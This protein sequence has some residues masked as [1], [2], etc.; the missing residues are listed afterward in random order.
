MAIGDALGKSYA[1]SKTGKTTI[2]INVSKSDGSQLTSKEK[3]ELINSLKEI[4]NLTK[5]DNLITSIQKI[6]QGLADKGAVLAV[7]GGGLAVAYT[8]K[9][10]GDFDKEHAQS[11]A[12]TENTAAELNLNSGYVVGAFGGGMAVSNREGSALSKTTETITTNVNGSEVVGL[13]ANGGAVHRGADKA[14]QAV[15]EAK[16]T[17]VNVVAGSVDG[18]FGGGLAV[19]SEDSNW[20]QDSS[21]VLTTGQST[22]NIASNVNKLTYDNLSTFFTSLDGG[23]FNNHFKEVKDLAQNAAIVGGGVAAGHGALSHVEKVVINISD[24]A[25]IQ[26]DIIAGGI[27]AHGSHS[28]VN[29]AEVNWDGGK[30]AGAIIGQGL[31]DGAKVANSTLNITGNVKIEPLSDNRSKINGFNKIVFSQGT[32][33]SIEGLTAGNSVALIDGKIDGQSNGTITTQGSRLD[34][35]KLAANEN[36]YFIATNYDKDKSSLWSNANLAFDRTSYFANAEEDSNGNYNITYKELSAAS[37]EEKQD[38]LNDFVNGLGRFGIQSRGIIEGIINNGTNT[39]DGAKSFFADASSSTSDVSNDLARGLLFGE[40]SGVTSNTISMAND[41]AENAFLRLSL[42]QGPSSKT[43]NALW[44]KYLHNKY[45]VNGL[46]S[47]FDKLHSNNTYD[48]FTVGL[49]LLTHLDYA[50]AGFAISYVDGD[51]DGSGVDNEY[52]MWGATIYGNITNQV[53]NLIAD[54]NY[55]VGDNDLSGYSNAK[56]LSASRDL[57]VLSVGTRLERMFTVNSTQIIPYAGLRYMNVDA[58]KYTTK[59][60]GK[61]AFENKAD[62]QNIWTVPVG[63]NLRNT[64]MT[65]NGWTLSPNLNVAYVSAFGD[66]DNNVTV[67]AGSGS[68][69]LNYDVIDSGS[70][71]GQV[72]LEAEY[73]DLKFGA[74]YSYQ[75][76]SDTQSNKFFVNFDYRF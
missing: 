21:K 6:T 17:I 24:G 59:Y 16:D 44:V 22:L 2:N 3:G 73:K 10:F 69:V 46:A 33:A 40:M 32:E 31:G 4:S 72:S 7:T 20:D 23:A 37:A 54:I 29:N 47:S 71:L 51:G 12:V 60:D 53:Y 34:I 5:S 15:V 70:C 11:E 9:T 66:T 67:H 45:E 28:T 41:I 50:K 57:S 39:N 1:E 75:K 74:G 61:V 35:S 55:S 36:K 76:G 48:G 38:A 52:D 30:F 8:D 43:E 65:K 27:A 63:V 64:T 58:D 18:L 19:R 62:S 49:D 68:S 42:T 26:G 13:F 14:G 56:R 25:N